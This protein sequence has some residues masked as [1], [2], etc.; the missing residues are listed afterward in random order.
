VTIIS[1]LPGGKT[2]VTNVLHLIDILEQ[3][4]GMAYES[5]DEA[6]KRLNLKTKYASQINAYF[7]SKNI[8]ATGATTK[9]YVDALNSFANGAAELKPTMDR[10]NAVQAKIN[11]LIQNGFTLKAMDALGGTGNEGHSAGSHTHV[12]VSID[13]KAVNL[14]AWADAWQQGIEAYTDVGS[15]LK[16]KYDQMT[17][18]LVQAEFGL[19][20]RRDISGANLVY[21]KTANFD[22]FD[23][24]T[25]FRVTWAQNKKTGKFVWVK[26]NGGQIEKPSSG[27][28]WQWINNN[29][30]LI[31]FLA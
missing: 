8:K 2:A 11:E 22:E 9:N 16:F 15:N 19:V 21:A 24:T 7:V 4:T 10:I 14:F 1:P 31:D 23:S 13:G 28:A 25:W 18:A 26:M 5:A 6:I 3:K 29:W 12:D 30:S 17:K 27:K 20:L